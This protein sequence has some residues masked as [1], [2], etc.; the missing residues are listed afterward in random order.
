MTLAALLGKNAGGTPD[1][2]R[3][4]RKS[5]SSRFEEVYL[6]RPEREWLAIIAQE[7]VLLQL[8]NLRRHLVI[9]F[10]T[11][12]RIASPPRMVSRR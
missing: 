7:S 2:F 12:Y 4:V 10:P 9:R 5:L 11:E 8:A 6:N 3:E 1:A